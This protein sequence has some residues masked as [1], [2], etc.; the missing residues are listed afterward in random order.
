MRL[1]N[2]FGLQKTSLVDYP[3]KVASVI[4]FPGCNL[5]CPYCHNPDLVYGRTAGLESRSDVLEYLRLRAPLLGGVVISGGEPLLYSDLPLFIEK[6]RQIP[7]LSVKVDTNGLL[8]DRLKD[9]DADYIAMDI[10]ALPGKY[11]LLGAPAGSE[12]RI[13]E[14]V[15]LLKGRASYSE[16]RTTLEEGLIPREDIPALAG[17][18]RGCENYFLTGF[19]PGTCLDPAYNEKPA[20]PVPILREYRELFLKEGIPCKIRSSIQ[21]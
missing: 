11:D 1:P 2:H 5:R 8:P 3:G 7:G 15:E 6:I 12:D 14:S 10:K 21:D 19:R 9:L 13:N 4:F 20:L 18:L 16:F 17:L